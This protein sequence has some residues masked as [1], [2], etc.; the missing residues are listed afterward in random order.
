[1][2]FSRSEQGASLGEGHGC[3]DLKGGEQADT[4]ES[5]PGRGDS[6]QEVGPA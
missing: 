6:M 4:W 3:R 5:G 2:R 1:M